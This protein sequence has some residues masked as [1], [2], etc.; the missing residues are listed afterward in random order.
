[1]LKIELIGNLGADAEVREVNGSKFVA[2]RVAHTDRWHDENGNVKD[3]TLWVDVTFN[4]AD[5]KLVP[6]LKQGV[7]LWVRGHARLR[8]YSSAK[9]RCMKAGLTVVA[10]EIELVGG[11]SDE[12]P[13]QLFS[14]DGQQMFEVAKFYQSNVETK[15]WKKD[16]QCVLVDKQANRYVVVKGGW[17]ARMTESDGA[18]R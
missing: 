2:M 11:S 8:V 5:S 17:V 14:L 16:D 18:E 6:Y 12:V 13:R 9:D 4:D 10:Q 1:M 7:K 3:S 15:E